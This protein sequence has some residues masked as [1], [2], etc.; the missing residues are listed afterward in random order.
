MQ[1]IDAGRTFPLPA[2]ESATL[3]RRNGKRV[4]E[5]FVNVRAR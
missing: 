1:R 4:R 2:D 3:F 5:H